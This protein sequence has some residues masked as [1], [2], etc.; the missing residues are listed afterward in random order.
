MDGALSAASLG[1]PM[2]TRPLAEQWVSKVRVGLLPTYACNLRCAHC[3]VDP[4]AQGPSMS[5]AQVLELVDACE[6]LGLRALELTGGEPFAWAGHQPVVERLARLCLPV[7]IATNGTLFAPR[8]AAALSGSRVSLC[9]SL[10]G[11]ASEHDALR[12]TGGHA[13]TAAAAAL[14]VSH[15]I[16]FDVSCTVTRQ[17]LD[18]VA[19]IVR[20]AVELGAD[21]IHVS[22]VQRLGGRSSSLRDDAWL[23]DEQC[24]ELLARLS[25]LKPSLPPG[26]GI[27]TRSVGIHATVVKHPCAACACWGEFCPSQKYW[28]A[29]LFIMP[30]GEVLPQSLHVHRRHSLGN[31]LR[32][33]LPALLAGYWGSERHKAF[34]R[35]TRYVFQDLIRP[36]GRPFY[37]WDELM[38]EASAVPVEQ[39]PDYRTI[40][41][42]YDH[43]NEI[44]EARQA[45]LLDETDFPRWTR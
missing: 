27:Y 3:Y 42:P 12:G 17:S 19:D 8:H 11:T 21:S 2:S 33:G 35:L 32:D 34:Q 41:H 15:A 38:K 4:A 30:D 23:D 10:D 31:A 24:V 9:L 37:F 40:S 14:C 28:P 43:T 1:V 44:E 39:L 25:A 29:Q 36:S 20:C 6:A 18:A 22:P 5:S 16:R 7:S 13:K 45:G 26:F